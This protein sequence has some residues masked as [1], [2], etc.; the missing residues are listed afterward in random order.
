MGMKNTI[1]TL[2]VFCV[3]VST[4][5]AAPSAQEV[6]KGSGVKGGM[7][8]YLGD[9]PEFLAEL[10]L[11]TGHLVHGVLTT[12]LEK[13]QKTIM[14]RGLTGRITVSK[15]NGKNLPFSDNL[16]NLMVVNSESLIVKNEEILRVLAP[17]GV[18]VLRDEGGNLKPEKFKN[19]GFQVSTGGK[20][21]HC[22]VSPYCCCR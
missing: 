11:D 4:S 1:N 2:L 5:Y 9:N 20:S 8:A 16:V 3:L 6:V 14:G 17:R 18:A 7:V 12:G 22:P 10:K 21:S 15:F 19:A 13:A